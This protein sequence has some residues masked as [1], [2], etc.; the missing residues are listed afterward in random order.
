MNGR[1]PRQ[2][3]AT[4]PNNSAMMAYEAGEQLPL[5]PELEPLPLAP[6][7]G[8]HPHRV[9]RM[10]AQGR[11]L[12]HRDYIAETDSWRLAAYVETLK[13]KL[14]WPVLVSETA[15]PCEAA[16]NRYIAVYSLA[17]RGRA[18][19]AEVLR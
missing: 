19:A 15:A 12:D 10:L 1:D 17:Q 18:I 16:P 7:P 8:T 13:N 3:P 4:V 5:M 6:K 9:L 2:E 11:S 14:G